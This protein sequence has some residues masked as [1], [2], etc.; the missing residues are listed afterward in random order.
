[1][2]E[3]SGTPAV[4]VATSRQSSNRAKFLLLGL[5]VLVVCAVGGLWV[6]NQIT[7]QKPL[8]RVLA[9]DPRNHVLNAKA[10]FDGWLDTRSV[11]FDLTDATGDASQADVFRV[12]LQYAKELRG[13][14]YERVILAAY[15]Q[16]KFVVPGYYFQQL[17]QDYDTQNPVYTVRTFS[18]HISTMDGTKPYPKPDGGIL[19]VVGEEMQQFNDFNKKW[20]LDDFAARHR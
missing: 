10:H 5:I 20:Y 11:V 6:Y 16:K 15:G 19:W 8:E 12:F 18:H 4:A 2:S 17:G 3:A 1:M 9:A 14:R 13:R 7:L